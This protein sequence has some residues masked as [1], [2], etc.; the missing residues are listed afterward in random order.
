VGVRVEVRVGV[1]VRGVGVRVTNC[2]VGRGELE[3]WGDVFVGGGCHGGGCEPGEREG[4][5][6]AWCGF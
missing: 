4:V 3:A 5:R 2:W 6:W 1:R